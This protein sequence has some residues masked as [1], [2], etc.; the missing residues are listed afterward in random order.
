MEKPLEDFI[1]IVL[2]V[3]RLVGEKTGVDP[4]LSRS[5]YDYGVMDPGWNWKEIDQAVTPL[6]QNLSSFA[7]DR[8]DFLGDLLQSLDM[9][10]REGLGEDVSYQERVQ[11]YL[12]VSAEII[13]EEEISGS[14]PVLNRN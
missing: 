9:M 12:Q 11:A 10:V 4:L 5:T 7:P 3:S 13:A 6:R 8:V 1:K 2:S 14:V